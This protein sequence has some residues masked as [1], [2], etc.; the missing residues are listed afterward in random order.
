MDTNRI[1]LVDLKT[2]DPVEQFGESH[3]GFH[4]GQVGA[5]AEVCA[6]A[7]T[8]EFGTD[9]ASD[10]EV[11]GIVECALVAVPR[12]G[13]QQQ[14]VTVG[15]R[16]VIQGQLAGDGAGQ[17][18]TGGVVAQG[19]LYPQRHSRGVGVNGGQ[20]GWVLVAPK[21]SVG[22]EFGGG[23]VAGD[24]HQEH[25][26]QDFVVGEPVA[27]DL[28]LQQRRRQVV[29]RLLAAL[30]DHLLVVD[31]QVEGGL[32][33]FRRH[34]GDAVFAVHHAVGPGAHVRPIGIGDSHQLGDDVHR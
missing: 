2:L 6:A 12:T 14:D 21:C 5:Q 16:C 27:V 29:G 3:P 25:E 9:V 33:R 7:E 23:L 20:L 30:G 18:L 31:D 24:H 11:V 13:Q 4:P 10:H 26:P 1:G 32:D 22:K 15:D 8:Q 34:V 19:L 17:D 28:G